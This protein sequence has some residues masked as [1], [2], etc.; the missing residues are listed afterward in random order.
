MELSCLTPCPRSQ[1][2][3]FSVQNITFVNSIAFYGALEKNFL[4]LI[5]ESRPNHTHFL[6][7]EMSLRQVR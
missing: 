7:I 1:T 2:V 3:V 6:E 4:I 5:T